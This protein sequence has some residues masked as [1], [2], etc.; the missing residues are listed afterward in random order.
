MF[1]LFVIFTFGQ[2]KVLLR[3]QEPSDSLPARRPSPGKG[4]CPAVR[5]A[6][7]RMRR[8]SRRCAGS[9]GSTPVIK[10]I[11]FNP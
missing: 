2:C 5:R 6:K 10:Q 3:Y 8:L 7:A 9:A 1:V 4:H 11:T